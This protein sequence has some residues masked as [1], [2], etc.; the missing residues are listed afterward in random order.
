MQAADQAA[1]AK[2][3]I[4]QANS[5][6]QPIASVFGGKNSFKSVIIILAFGIV[7]SSGRVSYSAKKTESDHYSRERVPENCS[8]G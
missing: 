4:P 2:I 8:I 1:T 5:M 7:F 3:A 6:Q